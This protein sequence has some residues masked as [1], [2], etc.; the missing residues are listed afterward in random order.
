MSSKLIKQKDNVQCP[1]CNKTYR[2]KQNLRQH[3]LLEHEEG[4]KLFCDQCEYKTLYSSNL[5]IHI[6]SVHEKLKYSCMKCDYQTVHKKDLKQHMQSIHEG[7]SGMK[8]H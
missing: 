3:F 2:S 1:E 4:N 7:M 8:S 6:E 5:R